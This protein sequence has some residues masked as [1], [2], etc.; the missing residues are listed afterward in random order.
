MG[1]QVVSDVHGGRYQPNKYDDHAI[2]FSKGALACA[3]LLNG[4]AAVA[5]IAQVKTLKEMEALWPAI[6]ALGAWGVGLLC[7]F[8]GWI[9]AFHSARLVSK[10]LNGEDTLAASNCWMTAGAV[11]LLASAL[12]FLAGGLFLLGQ[13][14]QQF[15][16]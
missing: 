1:Q 16:T 10:H 15:A 4:G 6:I 14:I 11:A 7:C 13:M 9:M 12:L 2:E 5:V 3:T 8:A